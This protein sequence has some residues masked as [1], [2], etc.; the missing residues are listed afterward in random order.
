[1]NA[2]HNVLVTCRRVRKV[3]E[4][5]SHG[6]W[7]RELSL[8]DDVVNPWHAIQLTDGQYVVC[9]GNVFDSVHR[10]CTM[11]A[12]GRETVHSH[13]GQP[14]SDTGQYNVPRHLAVDKNEFVF[15]AD[16]VNRRVTLLSPTLN[17]VRHV[18]ESGQ[19]NGCPRRMCLDVQRRLL[20]VADNEWDRVWYRAGRVV[21]FRV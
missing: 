20:Y 19:L 17:H 10:V 5:S 14:G 6:D 9:H 11:S 1:M 15:V 16:V 21:V 12:D 4:F 7:L 18:V 2:A 3:K 13:G 8:P